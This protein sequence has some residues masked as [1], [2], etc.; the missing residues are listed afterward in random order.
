M[1][2]TVVDYTH[3]IICGCG[4]NGDNRSDVK[5]VC[6]SCLHDLEF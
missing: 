4:L 1:V 3:C 6:K 5:N 2:Q